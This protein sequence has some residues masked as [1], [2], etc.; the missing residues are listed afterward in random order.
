MSLAALLP[1]LAADLEGALVRI[2]RGDLADQVRAAP[3]LG[4]SRD[5]FAQAVDLHVAPAGYAP[6][7]IHSLFDELGASL[8]LDSSGRLARVE[9]TGYE[10]ILAR[11]EDLRARRPVFSGEGFRAV[12]MF[13]FD[14]PRLFA[15]FQANP[16]FHQAV[17]GGPATLES[18]REDVA[19]RPPPEWPFT[20]KYMLLVIDDAGGVIGAADILSDL[21]AAGVWHVGLFVVATA[22][23]GTGRPHAI[24][25]ALEAW[26]KARGARWLRL[27]VVD[28]N[29]RGERFWR[30]VGYTEVRQRPDYE[31]SGRKHLL[32]VMAKPLGPADWERYRRLV[33]RDDPAAD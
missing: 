17:A 11:L 10:P 12:E 5:D 33:P 25:A 27:G 13:A 9:V 14:V 15:F 2:G 26:M 29:P 6:G 8:E 22:L 21:F 4:F 20:R 23:H 1:E 16:L 3:L 24:Y 28:A 19:A 31:T 32:H 18:V 7:E 30:R